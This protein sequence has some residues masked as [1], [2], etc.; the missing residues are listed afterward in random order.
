MKI[1]ERI[2]KS[3]GAPSNTSDL[4]LDTKQNP[5]ALKCFHGGEWVPIVSVSGGDEIDPSED[6]DVVHY[7]DYCLFTVDPNKPTITKDEA[8]RSFYPDANADNKISLVASGGTFIIEDNARISLIN[9]SYDDDSGVVVVAQD[10][11]GNFTVLVISS[12]F[13]EQA[14][15]MLPELG[16]T[17]PGFLL[18]TSHRDPSPDG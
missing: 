10:T 2:I 14:S 3:P 4:W 6:S 8:T 11:S 5:P 12:D 17:G 16:I 18:E 9:S 15:Q 7:S 13:V 1:Y